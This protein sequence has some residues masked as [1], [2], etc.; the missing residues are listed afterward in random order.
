[1]RNQIL[2][3]TTDREL[4]HDV[5]ALQKDG[6]ISRLES[7]KGFELEPVMQL[8]IDF[9]SDSAVGVFSA[10]LYDI[11]KEGRTN[12]TTINKSQIP[13]NVTQINI[14]IQQSFKDNQNRPGRY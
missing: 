8:I 6:V 1:M 10:W 5:H 12:K 14:L 13:N 2:L 3:E 4:A 11:M 7:T 9:A